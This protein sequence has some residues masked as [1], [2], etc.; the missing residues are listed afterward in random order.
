V[1]EFRLDTELHETLKGIRQS[2]RKLFEQ[3]RLNHEYGDISGQS[4]LERVPALAKR[5]FRNLAGPASL[6]AI[7]EAWRLI[8]FLE[9]GDEARLSRRAREALRVVELDKKLAELRASDLWKG[10][11]A[12]L[13]NALEAT[14]DDGQK[15]AGP[16]PVADV[17][18]AFEYTWSNENRV[19]IRPS[20]AN[21]PRFPFPSSERDHAL[22][23]AACHSLAKELSESV[24]T[25]IINVRQEYRDELIKYE[26]RLPNDEDDGNILLADAAARMLRTL[27]AAEVDILPVPFAASLKTF[28]EQ[29]NGLRPFYPQ[30]EAFY[31][32]VR[33]GTLEEPLP[34]DAVDGVVTAVK[35]QTPALFDP[36]V[37]AAMDE[38]APPP[39][40]PEVPEGQHA[41]PNQP[42]PPP[43][44]LG[45]LET[46]KAHSFQ[47]AGIINRLWEVFL[48]GEVI[49]KAAGAWRA[50]YDLLA[51]HISRILEW[52]QQ[53]LSR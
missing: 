26:S 43:D 25:K 23:L 39:V 6:R 46:T 24:E 5:N 13:R 28:L 29:H 3:L 38:S 37:G 11:A 4:R 31:R 7:K 2:V 48:K 18:S 41:E 40:L 35:E 14:D 30:I 15:T 51:P 17:P 12:S 1:N 22:R 10:A 42:M 32:D 19:V 27:F 52:L 50:T 9:G 36:S 49:Q 20:T 45:E 21:I 33:S 44:P 47:V 34:L 53:F 8:D 16:A